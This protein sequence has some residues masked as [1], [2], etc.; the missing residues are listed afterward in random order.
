MWWIILLCVWMFIVGGQCRPRAHICIFCVPSLFFWL[1][2]YHVTAV[3]LAEALT[4]CPARPEVATAWQHG[5]TPGNP[6]TCPR[7]WSHNI[8]A[9]FPRQNLKPFPS[10]KVKLNRVGLQPFTLCSVEGHRAAVEGHHAMSVGYFKSIFIIRLFIC[11]LNSAVFVQ[12]GHVFMSSL[13][14][15]Q[16]PSCLMVSWM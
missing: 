15:F 7:S 16:L 11:S 12:F 3:H 2:S 1:D 13:L 14:S 6:V 5:Y 4:L 10:L 9:N 8:C